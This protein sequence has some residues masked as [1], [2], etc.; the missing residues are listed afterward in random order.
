MYSDEE[1]LALSGI[2]HFAFCRRQWALIHIERRWQENYLT[3]SGQMMHQRAHDE[4][5]RE[6]RGTLLIVRGLFVRS[7]ELGLSGVCD[8]VEFHQ[9]EQGVPLF[10][11]DG[12]WMP[13]PVEYK[14]GKSKSGECDR[15]QVCAQAM[16][17]EEM[18]GCDIASG[19]CSTS[20]RNRGNLLLLRRNC[21]TRCE[22]CRRKCMIFSVKATFLV[23]A[24][25][26]RAR[27][28]L[29]VTS[30]C[31]LCSRVPQLPTSMR[32]WRLGNEEDQEHA[33]RVY[34]RCLPD[35]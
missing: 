25:G 19:F 20:K 1:L 26:R 14:R 11:E 28:A 22:S 33:V 8:I 2:Q 30:A 16:C 32:H 15:L 13:V 5:I 10:G 31:R 17:L 24:R 34:R 23:C 7:S 18:L 27:L 29:C 4:E 35:A 21:E 3:A 6:R 12:A 9:D